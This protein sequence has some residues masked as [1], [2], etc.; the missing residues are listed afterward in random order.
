MRFLAA[1]IITFLVYE[2]AF[3]AARTSCNQPP[4]PWHISRWPR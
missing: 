3:E 4:A 1:L 2:A